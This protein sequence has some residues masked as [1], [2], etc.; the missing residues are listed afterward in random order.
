VAVAL[1]VATETLRRRPRRWRECF[2]TGALLFE[3][4]MG[5]P[6]RTDDEAAFPRADETDLAELLDHSTG[7]PLELRLIL[8]TALA[9]H[10]SDR[11]SHAEEFS[12]ALAGF[13][14]HASISVGPE[15]LRSWLA[16]LHGDPIRSSPFPDEL[17]VGDDLDE[18][19]LRSAVSS[20]L[21]APQQSSWRASHQGGLSPM[22]RGAAAFDVVTEWDFS[23]PLSRE[24]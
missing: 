22:S 24:A 4:M 10:P 20:E 11:F 14:R 13:A 8:A 1:Y 6:I 16:S 23:S 5:R 17:G 15:A 7:V 21:S 18:Q 12:D 2:F 3:M 19:E 9:S